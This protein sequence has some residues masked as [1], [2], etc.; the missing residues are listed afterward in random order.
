[1]A[2]NKASFKVSIIRENC[3]DCN[4]SF[5][6]I[7]RLLDLEE[8]VLKERI[9]KYES[10]PLFKPIVIKDNLSLEEVSRIEARKLELPELVLQTEPRRFYPYGTL[11]AHVIGYLQELSPEEMKSSVY[12]IRKLG[13]MIGKTGVEKEYEERLV[14]IDG[15]AIEVVDSLGRSKEEIARRDPKPGQDLTLTLDFE[16]QKKAEQ[17]LEGREGSI[18]VMESLN[19]EILALANHPYFDPNKFINRF[20]PE[21]WLDLV[22]SQEFPLE[23]RAIRGL[24]SPGSIFKLAMALTA[25]DLNI[26]R[27]Q[28]TFYCS[29]AIRIYGHPFSC[30]F[31]PGHGALNLPN[32][33][34]H[35]CN[36]YFYQIGKLIGIENISLY[37]KRFGF[38]AKTGI[39]LPEEKEGLVP[40]PQWKE[41]V[42]NLPW[43]PGETI[44]VSIGQGP[45]LVTPLQVA[46]HTA[47]IANRG[48]KVIPH[49]NESYSSVP[50]DRE[51][52]QIFAE[53]SL[54]QIKHSV[55]EKVIKGMWKSV[56]EEGTGRGARV[57]GFDVCGKTGS[58]QIISTE[59]AKE[60]AELKKEFRTHSWFTGFAPREKPKVIVTVLV[61][62]GGK[63]GETA[64][65]LAKELFKL[66]RE[67][68]D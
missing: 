38:G 31:K 48:K 55:F 51:D 53:D 34:K 25:L 18:V 4:E 15:Q 10:L 45:L 42:R 36:I 39:D 62:F 68:Y 21:E 66:F 64:A 26:I 44:S 65:P 5:P 43:Y 3:K 19:G 61:E 13:D 8:D 30:W 35:S 58:T 54:I 7:A 49:L 60:L 16:L 11:A 24:Y 29:G 2:N 12:Q 59:K 41:R 14:G 22:K 27:D 50:V 63:G 52:Y 47:F 6:K 28:T 9:K 20:T 23:N 1:M 56:N 17:L 32:A 46:V 57:R 40:S 33:I 37:A 67:R